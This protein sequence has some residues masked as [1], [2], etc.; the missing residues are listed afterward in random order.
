[1]VHG[2]PRI[3]IVLLAATAAAL[4]SPVAVAAADEPLLCASSGSADVSVIVCPWE[5]P[6]AHERAPTS[7]QPASGP[8]PAA[9][10]GEDPPRYDDT[11][12]RQP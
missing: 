3:R 9:Q 11:D 12:D 7:W 1:M 4:T 10:V 6:A 8:E 5:G 2:M